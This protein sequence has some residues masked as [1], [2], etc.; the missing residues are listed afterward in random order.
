M[1][2]DG[3]GIDLIDYT[4]R[5]Y[6]MVPAE[7]RSSRAAR[8]AALEGSAALQQL[9]KAT[10]E[11]LQRV[12]KIGFACERVHCQNIHS[13]GQNLVFKRCG[14]VSRALLTCIQRF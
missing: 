9:P 11:Y 5:A 13:P 6:A 1:S 2:E 14:R 3:V 8:A 12:G 7:T 10:R 4:N